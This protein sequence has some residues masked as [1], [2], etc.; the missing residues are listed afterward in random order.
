MSLVCGSGRY[1]VF[2]FL[3][4]WGFVMIDFIRVKEGITGSIAHEI[5]EYEDPGVYIAEQFARID[6]FNPY[7]M[8]ELCLYA[9]KCTRKLAVSDELGGKM[10][11]HILC[12]GILTYRMLESQ[13]GADELGS[14]LGD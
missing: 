4:V 8:E 14:L 2:G 12:A 9:V 7:L 1:V 3:W 13:F 6:G 11:A 10:R 5:G